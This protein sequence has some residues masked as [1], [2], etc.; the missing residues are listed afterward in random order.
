M[1]EFHRILYLLTS[2]LYFHFF[3]FLFSS[4]LN[5]Q[6][7]RVESRS[8]FHIPDLTPPALGVDLIFQPPPTFSS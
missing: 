5:F 7:Y 4:V 3:F 6:L 2:S 1:A 8:R